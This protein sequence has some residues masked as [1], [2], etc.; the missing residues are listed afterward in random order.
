MMELML[1]DVLPCAEELFAVREDFENPRSQAV[2]DGEAEVVGHIQLGLEKER[3][4]LVMQPDRHASLE[5]RAN[6][7]EH[8]WAVGEEGLHRGL[9]GPRCGHM[10]PFYFP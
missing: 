8:L 4:L 10:I 6:N 2:V 9:L 1:E 7:F 5:G 3:C